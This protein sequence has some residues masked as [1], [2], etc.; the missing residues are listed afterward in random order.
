MSVTRVERPVWRHFRE[1]FLARA[2]TWANQ[3]GGALVTG[4][5]GGIRMLFALEDGDIPE[6]FLWAILDLEKRK[7]SRVHAGLAAG[8]GTSV[9]P[10]RKHWVAERWM[11]RDGAR[12]GPTATIVL[13]CLAC[14]ACCKGSKVIINPD[15]LVRWRRAGRPELARSPHVRKLGD[16][17][18]MPMSDAG[19]CRHLQLD[20]KCDIYELRPFNCSAF[21]A[22]AEPCLGTREDTFGIVD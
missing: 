19:P 3:G 6:L 1:K 12:P 8:L 17:L 2:V 13:D 22:G 20:N 9:I 16:K 21:P 10:R 14:G 11:E 7:W 5:D 15:D 18:L 4:E